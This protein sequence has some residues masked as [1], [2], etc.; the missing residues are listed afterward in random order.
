MIYNSIPFDFPFRI[1]CTSY[2]I[3]RQ[4]PWIRKTILQNLVIS[5]NSYSHLSQMFFQ[6]MYLIIFLF[7]K[8]FFR[9]WHLFSVCTGRSYYVINRA[10]I[11][12]CF[13]F[14]IINV[15]SE[16]NLCILW[17]KFDVKMI[18]NSIPFDF[19]FRIICTSYQ[20][21]RQ[22]PWIRKTI[23]QNLV[24]SANSYSHLSQMFFQ[25]MYL[26]IFL[27]GKICFSILALI[28]VC[29]GRSYYVIN[30]HTRGYQKVLSLRH[31]PHSD[32]TMLHT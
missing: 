20:I 15:N 5:A 10:C 18:Y 2:Q 31:F 6:D 9:F 32:S 27:F 25:D 17:S 29:S 26:I 8:Y 4:H 16:G 28:S 22:H 3:H 21:H 13:N 12:G 19:P 1:I 7:G 24:I 30:Q 14:D 23:L 11:Y